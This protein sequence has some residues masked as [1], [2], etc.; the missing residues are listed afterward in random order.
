MIYILKTKQSNGVK[1]VALTMG[2]AALGF[3]G[4]EQTANASTQID[5]NH[6]QIEEGDTL[7]KIANDYGTSVEALVQ[8][9]NIP[10]KNLIHI[11]D[12]LV[13]NIPEKEQD[14]QT[15]KTVTNQQ[16]Q[17]TQQTQKNVTTNYQPTQTQNYTTGNSAKDWIAA[18]ESGN[19]YNAV[20]GRYIGK[21]QLDASYLNGDYSIANQEKVADQY[22]AQRYGSWEAALAFHNSHGWY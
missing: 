3:I 8:T 7:G 21:Y 14:V 20:N 17:P 10:N 12:K 13:I 15:N 16:A 11:G 5:S 1:I 2:A 18:R 19:D 4:V 9:N 6:V 22:V